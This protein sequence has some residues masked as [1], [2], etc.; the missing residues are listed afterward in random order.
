MYFNSTY[1]IFVHDISGIYKEWTWLDLFEVHTTDE[2]IWTQEV[3]ANV[4]TLPL[5]FWQH[6]KFGQKFPQIQ[7]DMLADVC[8]NKQNS[9]H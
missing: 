8:Q 6:V 9:L 5:T 2:V 3:R 1:K 7:A 4:G